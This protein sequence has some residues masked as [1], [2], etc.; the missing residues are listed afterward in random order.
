MPRSLLRESQAVL[1]VPALLR[2]G[3][4]TLPLQRHKVI[5]EESEDAA[6]Q[7]REN[8]TVS[9]TD[10]QLGAVCARLNCKA[11]EQLM[12]GMRRNGDNIFMARAILQ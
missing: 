8:G 10:E 3:C 1:Q 7:L 6:R 12:D 2:A 4:M 5:M 9:G 11:A